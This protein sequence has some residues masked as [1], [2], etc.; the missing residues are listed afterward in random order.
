MTIKLRN[1]AS[2][3]W[4]LDKPRTT[5]LRHSTQTRFCHF[6]GVSLSR[7]WR[8][9]RLPVGKVTFACYSSS[10]K[11]SLIRSA[12]EQYRLAQVLDSNLISEWLHWWKFKWTKN[13]I[14]KY[15]SSFTRYKRCQNY[16]IAQSPKKQLCFY[17]RILLVALHSSYL[18]YNLKLWS[19]AV[20]FK[21]GRN[22]AERS[23][24]ANTKK[25]VKKR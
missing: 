23:P 17:C 18:Q 12:W 22:L 6:L 7:W 19:D 15:Q 1:K 5:N 3:G 25:I 11:S 21:Q 24:L 13:H 8:V 4:I 20:R 16:C 2:R 10:S 14:Q 9:L